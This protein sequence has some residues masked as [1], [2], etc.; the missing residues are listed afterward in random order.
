[1]KMTLLNTAGGY[2]P[3]YTRTE[4]TDAL[5]RTFGFQTDYEIITKTSM[6]TLIKNTK[7]LKKTKI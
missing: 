6:R 5:H 2:I 1:M 3:S 4:L 7:A